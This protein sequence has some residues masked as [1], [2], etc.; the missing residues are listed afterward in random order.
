MEV[1]GVPKQPMFSEKLKHFWWCPTRDNHRSQ[2]LT[3]TGALMRYGLLPYV[4]RPHGLV[5]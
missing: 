5:G 2:I 1:L 3:T 4:C